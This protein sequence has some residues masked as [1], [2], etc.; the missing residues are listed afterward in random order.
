[1]PHSTVRFPHDGQVNVFGQLLREANRLAN[2][3]AGGTEL[4]SGKLNLEL[5]IMFI[6]KEFHDLNFQRVQ[7]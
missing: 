7:Q 6:L 1:M 4:R 5:Q 3:A 2:S